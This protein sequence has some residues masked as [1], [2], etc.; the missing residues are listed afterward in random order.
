MLIARL[1]NKVTDSSLLGPADWDRSVRT[2]S[3]AILV[4]FGPV[5]PSDLNP[6]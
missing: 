2:A 3:K 5:G 4:E 1:N 6:T